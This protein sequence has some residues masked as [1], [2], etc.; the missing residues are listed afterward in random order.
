MPA[1]RTSTRS[2]ERVETGD[3][4][5]DPLYPSFLSSAGALQILSGPAFSDVKQAIDDALK[6]QTTRAP[7]ARALMQC[8]AWAA[9][10]VLF[11]SSAYRTRD[12]RLMGERK[13]VFLSLL[14]RFIRK[15]ALS[16]EEIKSLQNNYSAGKSAK[17]LPDLFSQDSGWIEIQ[18]RPDRLHDSSANLRRAARV[19]VKPR[20]TTPDKAK[21]VAKLRPSE[22][23][24]EL[25]AVALAIQNLLIDTTGRV[26][27]STI[28]S[29]VQIRLFPNHVDSATKTATAKEYELSRRLLLTDPASGGFL[30]FA[31]DAQAYLAASG[32]D[33]DFATP[34]FSTQT[35]VLARLQTRC[36]QCHGSSLTFLMTLSVQDSPP[37]PPVSVLNP[38]RDERAL[39]VASRKEQRDDF[40]SL[41]ARQNSR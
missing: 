15:L 20:Q 40:K 24:Q 11:R 27:P 29:D 22:T 9:Y 41:I 39:Y 38:I 4:A 8:D 14:A 35:P 32:N 18:L 7:I 31:D 12:D 37:V 28:I 19:F 16:P 3:R 34:I 25:D 33:Y 13:Q 23:M 17:E 26:V 2:F 21:F 10:D 5:I 30:E 6:E 1:L 36:I